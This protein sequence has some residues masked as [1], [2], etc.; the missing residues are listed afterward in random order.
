MPNDNLTSPLKSSNSWKNAGIL[1]CVSVWM[2]FVGVLVGR[3]TMPVKFDI[4]KL[5]EKLIGK[6]LA[7]EKRETAAVFDNEENRPGGDLEFYEDLK[8]DISNEQLPPAKIV[9][10]TLPTPEVE[11]VSDSNQG[12]GATK[13]TAESGSYTVQVASLRS[14]ASAKSIADNLI[15]KGFKAFV[16]SSS[17]SDRGIWYRVRIGNYKNKTDAVK[18]ADRMESESFKPIV[19]RRK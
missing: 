11:P 4:P 16:A 8:T 6:R 3:G 10:A 2:F 12:D 1:L 5:E 15:E 9:K 14:E 19:V 7:A 18:M 13:A 17:S